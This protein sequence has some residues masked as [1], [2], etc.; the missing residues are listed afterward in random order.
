MV[1]AVR[2]HVV[3]AIVRAMFDDDPAAALAAV[4]APVTALVAL[5]AGDR[6]RAPAEL[7]RCGGGARARRAG[8][9]SGVA[10]FAGAGHNLMRYRPAEVAA[11]ILDRAPRAAARRPH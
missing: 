3:E 5:G 6:G 1:R 10:A 2:P 8:R 9:R 4:D 11:A 7:R